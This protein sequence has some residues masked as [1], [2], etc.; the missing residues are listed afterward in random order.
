MT[1]V[2]SQSE[3]KELVLQA[4]KPVLVDFYADWCGPCAAMAPIVDEVGEELKD[5][6]YV[7]KVNV[8][9]C[10]D[11]A[12]ALRIMSIPT[13]VVFKDGEAVRMAVGGQD[14]V[15]LKSMLL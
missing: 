3:F 2:I 1:R 4:D 10:R 5:S 8:D 12:K 6:A 9:D 11:V 7:Y 14:A 15:A 13:F